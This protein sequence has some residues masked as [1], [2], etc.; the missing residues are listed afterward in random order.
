M[1]NLNKISSYVTLLRLNKPIGILLLLWPTLI[2]LW[3]AGSGHPDLRIVS[4]FVLG[5]I[6]MRS[7]GCV[8]ND[9]ADKNLDGKVR[10]TQTRPLVTGQVS[11]QE[12]F[13]IFGICLFLALLLVLQL[14]RLTQLLAVLSLLLAIIYPLMKRF[15]QL[16][17]LILG[18][19]FSMSI[20]MAFAAELNSIPIVAWYL[21]FANICWVVAY[22]TQYA[23]VDRNDDLKAGIKSTAILFGDYDRLIILFLQ[24]L[25]L[26]VFLIIGYELTLSIPYYVG[27]FIAAVS[28]LYQFAL[29]Y[30]RDPTQCLQAFLNN[31]FFGASI[32]LGLFFS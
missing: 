3:I 7:A 12:A 26:I 9:I 22:D 1:R 8:I 20:P 19:A 13:I 32:F 30:R 27:I 28:M 25:S 5:V 2:A 31:R 18:F 17:Q 21:V 11:R 15:M 24:T 16:P 23:M 29:I 4:I 10:R 6:I 14:N